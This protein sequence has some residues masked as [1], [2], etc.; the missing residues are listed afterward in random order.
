MCLKILYPPIFEVHL[1]LNKSNQVTL[2][3]SF[4]LNLNAVKS[5]TIIAN[6]LKC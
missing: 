1:L 2:I 6:G 5:T 3:I 4:L